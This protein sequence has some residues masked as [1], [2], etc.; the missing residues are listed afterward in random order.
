ML[1]INSLLAISAA[2]KACFSVTFNDDD[3]TYVVEFYERP[4]LF[5]AEADGV[6]VRAYASEVDHEP[7]GEFMLPGSE[8]LLANYM[9]AAVLN[10]NEV[11]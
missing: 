5:V 2:L 11:K 10:D 1:N 4:W 9:K 6:T 7:A 8:A 3:G